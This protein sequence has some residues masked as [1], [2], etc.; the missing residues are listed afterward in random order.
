MQC[1]IA[2]GLTIFDASLVGSSREGCWAA[3]SARC[4]HE[5][6]D[7]SATAVVA[8]G[9]RQSVH[10]QTQPRAT[11]SRSL[12]QADPSGRRFTPIAVQ[13]DAGDST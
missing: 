12:T 1:A 11:V 8:K 10:V 3:R 7:V 4:A 9:G 13:G 2:N 6:P 5:R